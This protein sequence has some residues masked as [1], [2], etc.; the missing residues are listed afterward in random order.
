V[1]CKS[2]WQFAHLPAS[3]IDGFHDDKTAALV[4][5][6]TL[7]VSLASFDGSD[8]LLVMFISRHC[9]YVQQVKEELARIGRD[10]EGTGLAIVA[11]SAND[12][13]S[14]PDDAPQKLRELAK[15]AGFRFP[16]LYDE[17]QEVAK[18]YTTACTPDFFL[19]DRERKLVYR[20]QL[21]SRSRCLQI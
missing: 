8:A 1:A 15:Q 13:T 10:H 19:F 7:V 11:I 18:S 4:D 6:L 20:G 2:I 9:N 21:V 17:S 14:Y 16:L 3:R 12:V 5:S